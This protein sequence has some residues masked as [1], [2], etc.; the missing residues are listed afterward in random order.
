MFSRFG[1]TSFSIPAAMAAAFALAVSP[2]AASAKPAPAKPPAVR[3]APKPVPKPVAAP[4]APAIAAPHAYVEIT[5]SLGKILVRLEAKRAPVT[6]TNFL[7]YV[8]AKKYDGGEFYRTTQSWGPGAGLV[9]GGP[10]PKLPRYP[11]IAHEPTSVS[12]LTHCGGALSMAR[13][14][15]GSAT[16]DFFIMLSPIAD[17]DAKPAPGDPGFA[18]FGEIVGGA[19]VVQGIYAA[20]VDPAKGDGVMKGQILAAPVKMLSVRRA[21]PPVGADGPP[22]SCFAPPK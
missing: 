21:A 6:V 22:K 7:R 14:A 1:M 12:G 5:T 10:N 20:P 18:V 4:A 15:P 2:V 8:D 19:D 16:S 11:V 9:Q 3:P 17:F 13:A